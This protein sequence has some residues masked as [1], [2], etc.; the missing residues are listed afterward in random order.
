MS[1]FLVVFFFGGTVVFFAA[2]AVAAAAESAAAF[3]LPDALVVRCDLADE[4][5]AASDAPVETLA[6]GGG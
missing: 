3:A 4:L 6:L 2:A 1:A 5:L